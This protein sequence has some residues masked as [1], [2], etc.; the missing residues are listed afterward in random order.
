VTESS[1]NSLIELLG[2]LAGV[3]IERRRHTAT[4][5]MALL[6][7][8]DGRRLLLLERTYREGVVYILDPSEEELEVAQ[9]GDLWKLWNSDRGVLLGGIV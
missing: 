5:A 1:P 8:P 6:R 9:E 3:K 2:E 4:L 7:R